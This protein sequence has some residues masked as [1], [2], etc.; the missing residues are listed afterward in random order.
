MIGI[1]VQFSSC[2]YR[3]MQFLSANDDDEQLIG[4]CRVFFIELHQCG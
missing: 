1:S 4:Y 2:S 3:N